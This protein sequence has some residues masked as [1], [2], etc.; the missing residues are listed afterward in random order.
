MFSELSNQI[1]FANQK[2]V[3]IELAFI[4]LTKPERWSR[5][6]IPSWSAWKKLERMVEEGIPA[7]PAGGYVPRAECR[8]AGDP[9]MGAAQDFS[10]ADVCIACYDGR[11]TGKWRVRQVSKRRI[12]RNAESPG[13]RLQ[14]YEPRTVSLLKAQL[15]DLNMIRN[16]WGQ[17]R[18][19]HGYVH[20]PEF[21]GN[22]SGTGGRQLSLHRVQ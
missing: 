14:T 1:R 21:P 8:I 17:D 11:S 6:W 19:R 18:P 4:K 10:T 9:M 13:F 16:E 22:C 7:M 5:T 15:E 12:R 2:R 3:L 20:P